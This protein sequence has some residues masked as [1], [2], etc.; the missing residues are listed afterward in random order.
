[1]RRELER[2]A[3][4]GLRRVHRL[5]RGEEID[6][7][8]AI[9]RRVDLRAGLAPGDDV[10]VARTPQ[11]RDVTLAVL[12]DASSSTAEH[13]QDA[14]PGPM[15]QALARAHGRGYRT[16]LDVEKEA[17]VL[18]MA[19]LE[20]IGDTYGIYCFSGTGRQDVKFQVLKDLDERLSDT[21]ASRFEKMRGIH[22]TRM[23]AAIR[24]AIRKL[25]AH[26]SRTKVLL[27]LSDG[28]PFDVDYGQE[29]GEGAEVA[30]AQHDTRQALAEARR[31]GITPFLLTVDPHGN[32]Y[33]R[34]MC[35]GLGYE[36][37]GEVSELPLR[38]VSLYRALTA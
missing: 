9:E 11:A 17:L 27:V 23:G 20:R 35:D 19:A 31:H 18:L 14:P 5:P 29:Y 22:T 6:L 2:V 30:Y 3:H 34:E 36:V 16:I 4:E 15:A 37:L 12:V 1:V 32:E 8:A 21:V 26:E 10:Y 33:L 24:H 7:D 38:L 28:R 13:A 25:R